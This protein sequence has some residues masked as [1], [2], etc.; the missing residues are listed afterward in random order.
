MISTHALAQD[1]YPTQNFNGEDDPSVLSPPIILGPLYA[2]A[3]A[4]GITGLIP[5]ATLEVFINGNL[6][7]TP[8]DLEGEVFFG[9][10]SGP[11]IESKVSVQQVWTPAAMGFEEVKQ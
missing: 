2:C 1:G 9:W 10:A 11:T 4:V 7:S 8:Q 5:G 6:V 3:D